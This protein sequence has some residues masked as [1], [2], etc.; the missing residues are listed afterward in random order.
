MKAIYSLALLI[1]ATLTIEFVASED[2]ECFNGG[3]PKCTCNEEGYCGE[4]CDRPCNLCPDEQDGVASE[5]SK[6]WTGVPAAWTIRKFCIHG[7]CTY[8][9]IHGS[10]CDCE[11]DWTGPHCEDPKPKLTH[12]CIQYDTPWATNEAKHNASI[13]Q[14]MCVLK[15]ER[16]IPDNMNCAFNIGDPLKIVNGRPTCDP[17][18]SRTPCRC[19][20][21]I[22]WCVN[23]EVGNGFLVKMAAKLNE[24]IDPVF[25]QQRL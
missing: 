9:K 7:N 10:T 12:R 1:L 18:D 22:G 3:T 21:P 13:V 24:Y 16:C 2:F 14:D 20:Y 17:K 8:D 15:T 11:A 23:L 5:P 4:H 6:I 19:P 25:F